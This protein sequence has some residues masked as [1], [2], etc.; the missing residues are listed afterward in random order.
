MRMA[1][2]VAGSRSRIERVPPWVV[3]QF[4]EAPEPRSAR[5]A[6]WFGVGGGWVRECSYGRRVSFLP[7]PTSAGASLFL[8]TRELR[9]PG[10]SRTHPPPI[11][12]KHY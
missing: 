7:A 11:L 3:S 2:G 4:D 1:T 6:V 9:L 5:K 8:Y 12:L 10:H